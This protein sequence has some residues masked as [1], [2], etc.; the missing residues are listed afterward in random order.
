MSS[1][2][3][4]A[5]EG[6]ARDDKLILSPLWNHVEKISKA[7]GGG[8]NYKVRCKFCSKMWSGSYSRVK[9]HFLEGGCGVKECTADSQTLKIFKADHENALKRKMMKTWTPHPLKKER[10]NNT[11]EGL[12]HEL[13]KDVRILHVG[14]EGLIS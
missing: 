14:V 13:I 6:G 3:T 11:F 10:L 1:S 7:P 12:N 2:T 4:P 8:G 5:A 9:K